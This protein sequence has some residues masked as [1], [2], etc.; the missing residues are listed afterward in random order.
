MR[1]PLV[2]D[3]QNEN[4]DTIILNSKDRLQ[5]L[6]TRYQ[7]PTTEDVLDTLHFM[8]DGAPATSEGIH[9][10]YDLLSIKPAIR[11]LH[12][13]AG[14]PKKRTWLKSIRNG[15]YLTWLL[16]TVKN[17]NKFFPESDEIQQ[18]HMRGQR[19]GVRS[20]KPKKNDK[21]QGVQIILEGEKGS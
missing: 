18:G 8:L 17:V 12:T 7:V 9:H 2:K 4:T 16:I 5:S 11:Y 14:F 21:P 19:Q 3:V 1:I 6:N 15:S 20:N 13:A 10:L